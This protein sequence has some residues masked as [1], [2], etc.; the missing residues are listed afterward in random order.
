MLQISDDFTLEDI[1]AIRDDFYERYK[2]NWDHEAM[3]KEI[4]EG[5]EHFG[6]E[7]KQ[8]RIVSV[9]NPFKR[10]LIC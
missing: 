7:L 5:A 9:K 8:R 4:R 3:I 10:G 1:R 2:D 6:K